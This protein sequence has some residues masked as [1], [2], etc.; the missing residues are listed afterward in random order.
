M[1]RH[2]NG[3]TIVE[4]QEIIH[5]TKTCLATAA[6]A[7]SVSTPSA[8][9]HTPKRDIFGFYPGMSYTRAASVAAD[10]CEEGGDMGGEKLPSLGFSSTLIKCPAGMREQFFTTD[11]GLEQNR[12]ES[13][14]LTFAADLPGQP[15][16]SVGYSF[17]SSSR[18][19]AHELI[20]AIADRFGIPRACEKTDINSMCFG[21]DLQSSIVTE[22]HPEGWFLSLSRQAGRPYIL[23]LSDLQITKDENA[24]GEERAKANELAPVRDEKP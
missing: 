9:D 21:D 13:V 2:T 22:L 10:V 1:Y 5:M 16:I 11:L 4:S 6:V 14:L 15:L 17:V 20:Q 7:L 19:P 8:A 23:I 18:A 24:A 3:R 12:D